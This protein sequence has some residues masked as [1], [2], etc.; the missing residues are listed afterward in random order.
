MINID[1]GYIDRLARLLGS[2]PLII[3]ESHDEMEARFAV[4]KLIKAGAVSIMSLESPIG[5]LNMSRGDGTLKDP[6]AFSRAMSCFPNPH[7]TLAKLMKTATKNGVRVCCHDM[8]AA[9]SPL[10]FYANPVDTNEYPNYASTF[11]PAS[12]PSLPNEINMKNLVGVRNEY[13]ANYLKAQFGSGVR[14]LHGLVL[15]VGS[16]HTVPEE[17]NGAGR[18]IQSYLGIPNDRV[19][20]LDEKTSMVPDDDDDEG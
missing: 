12:V 19:I 4:Y 15:L 3:G 5:P 18:T 7:V 2:G 9:R 14:I 1:E 8:P 20:V 6:V 10:N 11:L 13:S 17:C 16:D